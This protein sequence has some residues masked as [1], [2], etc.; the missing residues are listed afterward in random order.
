ML[1]HATG[2]KTNRSMRYV[3]LPETNMEPEHGSQEEEISFRNPYFQVPCQFF[4]WYSFL[5]VVDACDYGCCFCFCWEGRFLKIMG[6]VQIRSLK[7]RKLRAGMVRQEER[8]SELLL[9]GHFQRSLVGWGFGFFGNQPKRASFS[10]IGS[11][12]LVLSEGVHLAPISQIGWCHLPSLKRTIF[13]PENRA[14]SQLHPFAGRVLVD[15]P[16]GHRTKGIDVSTP[17]PP[18]RWKTVAFF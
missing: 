16:V 13:A 3:T 9:S 5:C 10:S 4:L 2:L 17:K 18:V 8:C 7:H 15:P 12:C 6:K 14:P 1:R 11:S